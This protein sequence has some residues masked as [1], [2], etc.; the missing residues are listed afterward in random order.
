LDLP[1]GPGN[2]EAFLRAAFGAE[3]EA[4]R[5][6]Y[7]LGDSPRADPRLGDA[8]AQ[9]ADDVTFRC[10]AVLSAELHARA[11]APVYLYHFDH[12]PPGGGVVR[13]S[14]EL[15]FVYNDLPV[16]A[17]GDARVTMQAY[18]ANFVRSGDPNGPSLPSWPRFDGASKAYLE[19]AETGPQARADLRGPFCRLLNRL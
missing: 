8:L 12:A 3:A 18:W 6:L 1:G 19:F 4:A 14:G 10:P 11:G 2:A 9:L 15:A 7:G 16:G 17:P 13:H 5:R